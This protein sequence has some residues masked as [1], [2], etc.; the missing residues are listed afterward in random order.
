MTPVNAE[1]PITTLSVADSLKASLPAVQA[2]P[3]GGQDPLWYLHALPPASVDS[4]PA[5]DTLA[6]PALQQAPATTQAK[7]SERANPMAPPHSLSSGMRDM[8]ASIP[9][10]LLITLALFLGGIGVFTLIG[11][12][13]LLRI[14]FSQTR[15]QFM[16]QPMIAYPTNMPVYAPA[17]ETKAEPAAVSPLKSA[18]ASKPA[19]PQVIFQDKASF[20]ALDY[21][22]KNPGNVRQAVHNATLLK[23]PTGKRQRSGAKRAA[24]RQIGSTPVYSY[25]P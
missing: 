1:S 11:G 6:G 24:S 8:I 19:L 9:K 10:W 14:L 3:T 2:Q 7:T 18:Y 15:Q 4:L 16:P 17:P 5:A 23:F 13:V 12:L 22:K 25:N 21:L 20:N